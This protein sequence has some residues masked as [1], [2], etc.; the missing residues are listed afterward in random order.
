MK[1]IISSI[2]LAAAFFM[3][4]VYG[5]CE[6]KRGE[7]LMNFQ[8]VSDIHYNTA[9]NPAMKE[10]FRS[11]C[12]YNAEHFPESDAMVVAG[13]FT[14][15]GTEDQYADFFADLTEL[16]TAKNAIVALGNH[17]YEFS[18][19]GRIGADMFPERSERYR[20]YVGNVLQGSPLEKTYYD[21][22]VNGYHIILLNT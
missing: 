6:K 19:E 22:W 18:P 3:L 20:R 5:G 15:W 13:D 1:K 11:V 7:A 14:V 10:K 2:A 16:N 4:P 12:Q 9:H 21:R 17:E 8:I